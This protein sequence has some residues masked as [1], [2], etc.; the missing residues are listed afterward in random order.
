[1]AAPFQNYSDGTFL[2]DLV[3]RPEFLQYVQE[4]VYNRCQWIQSGVVTRNTALDCSAGGTRVRVPFFQPMVESEEVITSASDWGDSGQGYL[5]P[6]GITAAEQVMTI[7][8]RGGAYAADDLSRLGSGADALGAIRSY[9]ADCILKL[10]TTTLLS[11]LEG[12]FDTALAPNT[13]DASISTSGAAEANFLSASNVV[14][15]Q[16]LL[17]ERGDDLTVI[18]MHSN[19]AYYL[20]TVGALT[21]STSALST[22]GDI[23]WGGGGIGLTSTEVSYFMGMRVIVDDMLKPTINA[24]GADQYPVYLMGSGSVAEGVQ[25]AFFTEADRNI[26][27]KQDV[28][29]WTHDYGFH[30]FGTSWKAATDNPTNALLETGGNW[31]CVYGA[32]GTGNEGDG[33]KLVPVAKLIVNS[34]LAANV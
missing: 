4:E 19:V 11:Q 26:L 28:L 14:K 12:I 1:V 13:L 3:V 32:A 24:G 30:L 10:R 21:F 31:E 2:T 33:T 7:L 9:L 20:R 34:P 16:A 15:T 5:T 18:A 6:K 17:G 22:G 27:S 23:T 8:H 25:R 29:S